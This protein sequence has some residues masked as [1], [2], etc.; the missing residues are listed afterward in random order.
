MSHSKEARGRDAQLS[1][2]NQSSSP[3]ISSLSGFQPQD[4]ATF[5]AT[6]DEKT[7]GKRK[8]GP[9]YRRIRTYWKSTKQ[10][11]K[12]RNRRRTVW[13]L[14]SES[15][16]YRQIAAKLSISEKT[17]Q[18]DMA[19]VAPYW[20]RKLM[21]QWR[22]I[23]ADRQAEFQRNLSG[24]PLSQQLK[25]LL[26]ETERLHHMWKTHDYVKKTLTFT[27]NLDEVLAGLNGQRYG[28]RFITVSP[29]SV[30]CRLHDLRLK[31]RFKVGDRL[32]PYSTLTFT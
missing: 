16:T 8:R 31:F 28:R 3:E 19:K 2:V 13:Q 12:E 5:T 23:E 11:V 32:L 24:L 9:D 6:H 30:N 20:E 14:H 26:R 21:N 7:P 15:L 25:C 18:R 4:T 29:K 1:E 17:V 22:K 27:I 10:Y